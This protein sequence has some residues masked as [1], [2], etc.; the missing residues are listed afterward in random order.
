MNGDESGSILEMFS[1]EGKKAVVTGASRGIGA[2][3][4]GALAA[5]G[6][7]VAILARTADA[8]EEAAGR[9]R[10]LGGQVL[11][12]PCDV[13]QV[14]DVTAACERILGEFGRVDILVNNAGGPLFHAP[15]LHIRDDGW[16]KV[17]DLNLTSVFRFCQRLGA[18]MVEQKSGSIINI[19]A[20]ED[21]IWPAVAPYTSAKAAVL[22]LTQVLAVDWGQFGVRVNA[23]CPGN[24]KTGMNS[25]YWQD[26]EVD[27]LV[28]Q[29]APL[30]GWQDP[31]DLVGTILWLASEASRSVTGAIIPVDG[32]L[33]INA[34]PSQWMEA[35]TRSVMARRA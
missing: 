20:V 26:P 35:T 17:M 11:V 7:D 25:A 19:G 24:V 34:V 4:A 22:H 27:A 28:E 29:A 32:G 14:D 33:S 6:S 8:L 1:L 12:V 16:Q 18:A 9:I 3:I 21:K 30:G 13:R 5:A 31:G 23:I 10:A 2:G 15:F